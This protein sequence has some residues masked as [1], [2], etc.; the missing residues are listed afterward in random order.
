LSSISTVELTDIGSGLYQVHV[1]GIQISQHITKEEAL[2]AAKILSTPDSTVRVTH[3][4]E[5]DVATI[6]YVSPSL[7]TTNPPPAPGDFQ[8]A[9]G[10]Y[11][12][13]APL[14]FPS[15]YA[16]QA[17]ADTIDHVIFP[18]PDIELQPYARQRWAQPDMAYEIPICVRGGSFPYKM[19]IDTGSTNSELTTGTTLGS[20]YNSSNSYILNIPA[21]TISSLSSGQKTF[22][23]KVTDQVGG[24]LRVEWKIEKEVNA[25][26]H[27]YFFDKSYSGTES[28]TF[29]QPYS[30]LADRQAVEIKTTHAAK[31]LVFKEAD[32][33][34]TPYEKGGAAAGWNQE[35]DLFPCGII[36]IPGESPKL[37]LGTRQLY[38]SN[39]GDD[40]FCR[41]IECINGAV[42]TT[43]T[44]G[45]FISQFLSVD[46]ARVTISDMIFDT[47]P[48]FP[49][50]QINVGFI[51]KNWGVNNTSTFCKHFAVVNTT[52]KN[53]G[54]SPK[55]HNGAPIVLMGWKHVLL[56]NILCENIQ[57][58]QL[59]YYKHGSANTTT[60]RWTAIT[61]IT[62][63][64]GVF[65]SDDVSSSNGH[66]L[67]K[68][69][70]CYLN[71][72]NTNDTRH[73]YFPGDDTG[74]GPFYAYRNTMEG[75]RI[76]INNGTVSTDVEITNNI[77]TNTNS[78][79]KAIGTLVNIGNK[80]TVSASFINTDGT[81]TDAG[82]TAL[83]I[84]ERGTHGHEIA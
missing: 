26:D 61:G 12:D 62:G 10:H 51:T 63:G 58:Q 47:A 2:D 64:N 71:I 56:D 82:M 24:E 78:L 81:L 76:N 9:A 33:Q 74:A 16:T 67:Q 14:P 25:L 84:S 30:V 45:S 20:L 68:N 75:G 3:D 73:I 35:D 59:I 52:F 31:T 72:K 50:L 42:V 29:D 60:R 19:E 22:V 55:Q 1:D 37:D 28:G 49:D 57:G 80:E 44:K 53:G 79:T 34:T 41:G 23:I 17:A 18:R 46:M 11:M 32:S 15:N 13:P 43:E 83:N 77:T 36:N 38:G 5:V 66:L 54:S 40:H 6:T 39:G 8:L 69:E 65:R 70:Y 21:S 27:F 4:Y 48:T 7:A